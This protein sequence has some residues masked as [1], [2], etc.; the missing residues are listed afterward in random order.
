[1]R[2][3]LV[4]ATLASLLTIML[5]AQEKPEHQCCC[6][7]YDTGQCLIKVQ[8][9]VDAA[10]NATY[11]LALQRWKNP[12]FSARLRKAERAWIA[13]RDANCDAEFASYD[14]GTI[15][16]NAYALCRIRLTRN[17]IEEIKRTYME[18]Q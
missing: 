8:K 12:Q 1:M 13:Y 15:A 9:D 5:H 7:T 11:R 10:L 14:G 17:R 16:P 18:R 2:N 6:T 4:L 3:V